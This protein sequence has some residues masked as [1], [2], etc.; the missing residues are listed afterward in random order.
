MHS[1]LQVRI[2]TRL[3]AAFGAL[4]LLL[5]ALCAYSA[6]NTRQL[7]AD[8][9]ATANSDLVRMNLAYGLGRNVA[10]VARASREMLLLDAAGPL[11]KQRALVTQSLAESDEQFG[12]LAAGAAGDDM[13]TLVAQVR[14]SKEAFGRAVA[15][16]LVT[17]DAGNP[18]DARQ[19]LLIE[20][21]PV[22]AGYE[23]ALQALSDWVMA[24]AAERAQADRSMAEAHVWTMVLFG[25]VGVALA[26]GAGALITRSIIRPLAAAI[27]AARRIKDGD[28]TQQ[29]HV[30]Q[31]DEIGELLQAMS[32]MQAH[33]RKGIE[34]VHRAAGD[35]SASSDEIA[36]G[37]ADLST[38][39]ERAA[40]HL[41]Q[42]ASAME[43]MSATVA[44]S[45]QKSKQAFEV[46]A[47]ARAAVIEGGKSVDSLVGTMTRI[48]ESSGRIRDIISVIDGIAFQ[49]NILALN[50]AVEAARAGEQGRGFAVVAGEVRSLAA[51]AA[52][53]AK[54]IKTLIDDSAAKVAQG[55]QTVSDFGERIRGIVAEVVDVRHLIEEVSVASGQQE[56]GIGSINRS[57]SNLDQSTQQNAAL[58]EELAATTQSLKTHA[59]RLVSAVGF[60]RVTAGAPA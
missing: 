28:L 15:K 57:V 39:T 24:R 41:Q 48:A 34:D 33:L 56:A 5:V 29:I 2:G 12:K 44:G 49:T 19:A 30:R 4:I 27:K 38:R 43:E 18:D 10:I 6:L 8:L 55:T 60:F 37:N 36:H 21:R 17:F 47:K 42:T 14:D 16:Y 7:A 53:A 40:T 32:E 52:A 23:K 45:S 46:A 13:S 3:A 54:E 20:L 11:K 58:V 26:A 25:I 22:Q 35:V 31:H 1:L 51:R 50:A 9:E 59:S